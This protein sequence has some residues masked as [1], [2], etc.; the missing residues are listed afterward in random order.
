MKKYHPEIHSSALAPSLR[1]KEGQN[2]ITRTEFDCVERNDGVI[3][4]QFHVFFYKRGQKESTLS[5]L[6]FE[7]IIFVFC[8]RTASICEILKLFVHSKSEYSETV[9][10]ITKVKKSFM[11][12]RF[13]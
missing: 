5:L 13:R 1:L 8:T 12:L 7:I 4:D 2:E 10:F 9:I 11:L 3:C 6:Y